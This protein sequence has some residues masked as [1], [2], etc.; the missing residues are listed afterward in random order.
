VERSTSSPLDDLGC[1]IVAVVSQLLT[2]PADAPRICCRHNFKQPIKRGTGEL[3]AEQERKAFDLGRRMA[4][5]GFSLQD[6]PFAQVHPRF[7]AQWAHGYFAAHTL[8]GIT[9]RLLHGAL[10]PTPTP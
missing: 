3:F 6:N 10:E 1:G 4:A 5:A 7:A 9:S 8:H 2:F